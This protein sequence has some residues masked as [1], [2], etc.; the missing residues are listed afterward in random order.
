MARVSGQPG[1]RLTLPCSYPYEDRSA[2]AQL[3][4]Q[5]RGPDN[6]L[7]CHYIKHKAFQRCSDGYH[8][9]YRPGSVTLTIQQL[10][11]Q[12]F[13]PHVCSVS[14]R[15]EFLDYSVTLVREAGESDR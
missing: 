7:L 13:G 12:D 5:W 9:T 3:S 11:P 8:L 10:R 15:D 6:Q 2:L 1:R 14:K 4:V